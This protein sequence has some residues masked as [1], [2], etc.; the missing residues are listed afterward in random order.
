MK[1]K[2]KLFK[3]VKRKHIENINFSVKLT[4]KY[5]NL[6]D[7]YSPEKGDRDF[8]LRQYMYYKTVVEITDCFL[9]DLEELEGKR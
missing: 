1:I 4:K 9:K 3:S 2:K 5:Q 7:N 8:I 6:W